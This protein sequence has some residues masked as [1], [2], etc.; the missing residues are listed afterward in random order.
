M[1]K[2]IYLDYMASK[3]LDPQ[4]L[5][6]M[7]ECLNSSEHFG[8]SSSQHYFG[9]QA[10]DLIEAARSQV[11]SLINADP[12]EIIWTS[13]ATEAN[14]LALKGAALF[15]QR[16]GKHIITMKTEHQSVLNVCAYLE[17]L[18]FT[19]TYLK[20]DSRG[21]LDLA[22]FREA[23]RPDTILVS[24]MWVN[25]ETGVIQDIEKISELT[26][27]QG[28]IFHV[29]AVQAAGNMAIDVRN[30]SIDLLSLSG[31]KLYGPKG[32]GVLYIRR[33]PRIR[34]APQIHGGDQEYGL[35]AGTL[36]THQIAGMGMA[37]EVI[38]RQLMT[39]QNHIKNL[40]AFLWQELN[41][42]PD[43]YLNGDFV[44]RIPGCLNISVAGIEAETLLL[45]LSNIALSMG[46]A[47]HSAHRTPSHV[48]TAMGLMP[49]QTHT[50]LRISLGRFT[51]QDEIEQFI[52]NLTENVQKLRQLSPVWRS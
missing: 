31:H 42:L 41:G 30:T 52:A 44:K 6:V 47:C 24:I 10:A 20:P 45:S 7:S 11:A 4:V 9:W 22:E 14:N 36:P 8:N 5:K 40:S 35:R 21:L 12:R 33:N 2:L 18:G 25:N 29:D 3:P 23:I 28:I 34:L 1:S 43:V 15:Y 32:I 37:C 19:V 38:R 13:G 46:S 27:Q 17:T 48:L 50:A 16:K 51:Q 26:R 49:E 39:D